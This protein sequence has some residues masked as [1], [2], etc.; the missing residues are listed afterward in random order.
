ML[1]KKRNLKLI[2]VD[3]YKKKFMFP[4]REYYLKLGFDFSKEPFEVSGLEF[5]DE[6]KKRLFDASL[7]SDT[8]LVLDKLSDRGIT[9]SILSA[10]NQKMLDKAIDYYNL[11]NKFVGVN[12]LDDYYANSKINIGKSW[13]KSL[14]IDPSHVLMV[15]DTV[16][17]FEVSQAMGTGCLLLSGGHNSKERL[18]ETGAKVLSTIEFLFDYIMAK[19]YE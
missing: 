10:Q 13:I 2:T 7:Y 4:I 16:H 14:N 19:N 8:E 12:G 18:N 3:D 6:F 17:D 11:K 1:L 9:H 15:G 5:I